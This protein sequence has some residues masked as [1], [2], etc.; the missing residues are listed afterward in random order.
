MSKRKTYEETISQLAKDIVNTAFRGK[1]TIPTVMT[2]VSLAVTQQL[3][4][5]T[6]G[7]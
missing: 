3:D 5:M 6:R 4:M 2:D 7:A 1:K